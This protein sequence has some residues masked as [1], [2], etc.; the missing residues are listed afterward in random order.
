MSSAEREYQLMI[1]TQEPDL[2]NASGGR[3][4]SD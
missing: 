4:S 3:A 2:G 1:P